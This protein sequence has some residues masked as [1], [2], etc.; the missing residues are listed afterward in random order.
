MHAFVQYDISSTFQFDDVILMS[1]EMITENRKG[2]N[3]M[4]TLRSIVMYV[5][6]V[7]I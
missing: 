3:I 5:R 6:T 2:K 4:I 1:P 7:H